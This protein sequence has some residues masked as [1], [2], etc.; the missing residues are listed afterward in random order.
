MTRMGCGDSYEG[1][2]VGAELYHE[3]GVRAFIGP[4]CSTGWSLASPRAP[5]RNRGCGEDGDLLEYPHHCLHVFLQHAGRQ[6]RLPNPGAHL[7]ENHELHRRGD[8]RP[9]AALRME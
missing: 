9:A 7:G 8:L 1:V 5:L 2:A 3:Q 4:Y 6:E